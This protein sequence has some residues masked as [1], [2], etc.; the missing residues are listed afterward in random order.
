MVE[1]ALRAVAQRATTEVL[2]VADGADVAD[3]VQRMDAA[4][5]LVLGTPAYFAMPSAPLK[6]ILDATWEHAKAGRWA[7]KAGAALAVESGTGGELAA[8]GLGQF[9][10]MHRMTFLGY[11]V[12]RGLKEREVLYDMKA[13]RGARE[14]A[15]RVVDYAERAPPRA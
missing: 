1:E 5:A 12:G 7:G 3:V 15:N 14:L 10:T 4:D 8:V 11:V 2:T 13:I 6:A 9:F